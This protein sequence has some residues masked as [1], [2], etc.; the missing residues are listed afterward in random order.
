MR[1]DLKKLLDTIG[2]LDKRA[3]IEKT[4]DPSPVRDRVIREFKK[5]AQYASMIYKNNWNNMNNASDQLWNM[6]IRDY[7][8]DEQPFEEAKEEANELQEEK[9]QTE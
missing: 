7:G 4:K 9:T 3:D 5:S 6:G 2:E 1:R 8:E